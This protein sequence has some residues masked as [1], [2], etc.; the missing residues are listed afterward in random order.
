MRMTPSGSSPTHTLPNGSS[1]SSS[2][3]SSNNHSSNNN[4][5]NVHGQHLNGSSPNG[6]HSNRSMRVNRMMSGNGG[7]NAMHVN[8]N[9]NSNSTSAASNMNLNHFHRRAA[10]EFLSTICT[11]LFVFIVKMFRCSWIVLRKLYAELYAEFQN[12]ETCYSCVTTSGLYLLDGC[13]RV[14]HGISLFFLYSFPVVVQFLNTRKRVKVACLITLFA[15]YNYW[16]ITYCPYGPHYF[17]LD[18]SIRG[19]EWG[20][21]VNQWGRNFLRDQTDATIKNK[22]NRV[23]KKRT[24]L[25]DGLERDTTKKI[26]AAGP[27]DVEIPRHILLPLRYN[28]M[29]LYHEELLDEWTEYQND[30]KITRKKSDVV[31]YNPSFFQSDVNALSRVAPKNPFHRFVPYG[32]DEILVSIHKH[33]MCSPLYATFIGILD[34]E[35]KVMVWSICELF[36]YGGIF[37]GEN[38]SE[39]ST[40]LVD[41]LSAENFNIKNSKT[42]LGV[43]VVRSSN[44]LTGNDDNV[45]D[46]SMIA[47]SPR[48]PVLADMLERLREPHMK[49]KLI[50][51]KTNVSKVISDLFYQLILDKLGDGLNRVLRDGGGLVSAPDDNSSWMILKEKCSTCDSNVC[52]NVKKRK[53]HILK[54]KYRHEDY[55]RVGYA[56]NSRT[57]DVMDTTVTIREQPA[58]Y[59]LTHAKKIELIDVLNSNKCR[60]TWLCNRCLD[61]GGRGNMSSCLRFCGSCYEKIMCTPRPP[62]QQ[63]NVDIIVDNVNSI[64]NEPRR[65]IPRI[66]HQTWFEDLTPDRYPDLVRLQNSW[67]NS[68]WDYRF[69]DDHSA[70]DFIVEHYPARFVE[71]YDCLLPGAYKADFFR[72]LVLLKDGGVYADIDVM[73]DVNLDGFVHPN[74]SFFAPIDSVGEECDE[75]FCLWNGFMG[76]SPGHPFLVRTVERTLN[77]ILSRADALDMENDLCLING[78]DVDTWKNRFLPSIMLTGPC[79][80]GIAVNEVMDRGSLT[81]LGLGGQVFT[82]QETGETIF[83]NV[84]AVS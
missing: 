39:I 13:V 25:E 27:E 5:N 11:C 32:R 37:F 59:K 34:W 10:F 78:P 1:G 69:Y 26:M 73:L 8:T 30:S 60:P 49:A 80:L 33:D 21:R 45:I 74:L 15:A 72:Y 48:N 57:I 51:H 79:A 17:G 82:L 28:D 50:N 76:S 75:R 3:N 47:M 84:L 55:L 12:Q 36:W 6:N 81:K 31:R 18:R 29:S 58:P 38:I 9:D 2:N 56:G 62:K 46:M 44:D 70:R 65:M 64:S 53:Q 7:P 19:G 54:M 43:I 14:V 42:S 83:F 35:D 40:P 68:G 71:A 23:K 24:R 63:V 20:D 77:L 22:S 66:I 16:F 61:Y 67:L 52:C 41:F 4:N